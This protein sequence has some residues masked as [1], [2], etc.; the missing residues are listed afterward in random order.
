MAKPIEKKSLFKRLET[1]G[2]DKDN[3]ADKNRNDVF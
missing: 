3:M 2:P 1:L